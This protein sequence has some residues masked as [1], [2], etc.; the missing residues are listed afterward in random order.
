MAR[1]TLFKSL[2]NQRESNINE[3]YEYIDEIGPSEIQP[4]QNECSIFTLSEFERPVF[5]I[6]N[7]IQIASKLDLDAH[8]KC[9]ESWKSYETYKCFHEIIQND[10]NIIHNRQAFPNQETITEVLEEDVEAVLNGI[11]KQRTLQLPAIPADKVLIPQ[12]VVLQARENESRCRCR[13]CRSRNGTKI[14][15]RCQQCLIP[16][17]MRHLISHCDK[18][19]GV[20]LKS[21]G[22]GIQNKIT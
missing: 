18:C 2:T 13:G 7:A 19:S 22:P 17:C 4:T 11:T 8:S 10:S 21:D 15:T 1:I 5:A 16:Y 3:E 14:R 12:G 9:L 20:N 6:S